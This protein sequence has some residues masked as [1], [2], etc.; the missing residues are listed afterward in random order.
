MVS[1]ENK[2][3]FP[4]IGKHLFKLSIRNVNYVTSVH[5][6]DKEEFKNEWI[7]K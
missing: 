4:K 7:I 2:I 1:V 5:K 3:I 6:I